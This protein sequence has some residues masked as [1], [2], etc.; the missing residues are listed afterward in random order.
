MVLNES[1][2]TL[3]N[4]SEIVRIL[5]LAMTTA[6]D[7]D[8][9]SGSNFVRE[10][11]V[12]TKSV[13]TKLQD[14]V[15]NKCTQKSIMEMH[16]LGRIFIESVNDKPMLCFTTGSTFLALYFGSVMNTL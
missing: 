10:F 2:E 15:G 12:V 1:S 8:G 4:R 3:G 13:Q 6:C 7:R 5:V 14:F 16:F 11:V 9:A